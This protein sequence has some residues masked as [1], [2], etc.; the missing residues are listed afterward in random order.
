MKSKIY[1]LTLLCF[2]A[3]CKDKTESNEPKVKVTFKNTIIGLDFFCNPNK[4]TDLVYFEKGEPLDE[5]IT[6]IKCGVKYDDISKYH[7][8]SMR[9]NT[10]DRSNNIKIEIS[11]IS[12]VDNICTISE[13]ARERVDNAPNGKLIV[14]IINKDVV[15]LIAS[16]VRQTGFPDAEGLLIPYTKAQGFFDPSKEIYFFKLRNKNVECGIDRINVD[17]SGTTGV[18]CL[19]EAPPKE[20]N[21]SPANTEVNTDGDVKR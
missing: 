15:K 2:F 16:N 7:Y 4:E 8:Y 21:L 12:C 6:T 10:P 11:E 20:Q 3:F 18:T 5:F 19:Q 14:K 9:I 17:I 13:A 1:L